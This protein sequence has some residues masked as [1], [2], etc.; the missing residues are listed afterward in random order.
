MKFIN[1]GLFYVNNSVTYPPF[2][3]GYYLE[4]F[5]FEFMKSHNKILD[6]EGRL[7]IPAL[8]TNF[9]I[10][11]W[12]KY[13]RSEMQ[14]S[15]N[16][17]IKNN[18][19]EKGYFTVVQHDDGP[20]LTL[21]NNTKVYGACSGNVP[22][23]L[24]YEDKNETLLKI[25]NLTKVDYNKKTTLCSFVGTV[26]HP[27]RKKC[28]DQLNN[29]S[30][31]SFIYKTSW[32]TDINK[33]SQ[34]LFIETT[35]NSRFAL[36]PRGY[37]RSSF[38]FF[39]ILQLGVIPV[40]VWNDIEWLPYKDKIDYKKFCISIH[41]DEIN[42]L[43]QILNNIKENTYNEMLANYEEIK[44]M[45]SL[46]NICEYITGNEDFSM[47]LCS[48]PIFDRSKLEPPVPDG[49]E[50]PSEDASPTVSGQRSEASQLLSSKVALLPENFGHTDRSRIS[51]CITTM[52]RFDTFLSKNL[53][54]Y[55][56]FLIDELIDEIIITDENGND[57]KKISEKYKHLLEQM[58]NFK[59]YKNEKIL[60]VFKNKLNACIYASCKYIALIDSDNFPDKKYFK[61]VKEY[62]N[63]NEKMFPEHIILAPSR[64]INHNDAPNLNYKEFEN[65]II[66]K[67]NIIEHIPKIK[68]QV[69]L[70]TGNYIISKSITDNI[71]YDNEIMDIISGCDVVY[72]NLLAFKQFSDLELHV[73]EGLEYSHTEHKDGEYNKRD[74]RCDYFRDRIIMPEYYRL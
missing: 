7:Y 17:Y 43:P 10:E 20:M 45:F 16:E 33:D 1:N 18:L 48:R 35:L 31:F 2:K 53:D 6:K 14:E 19:S 15:L 67:T 13:K 47:P 52:D 28:I 32:S 68:F 64:S 69:L 50:K 4:E 9:Q 27:I 3:N 63:K 37:G 5:F 49:S 21:P 61:T 25:K 57:Y 72:F 70:N 42:N 65:K 55:I 40:Y 23:P 38:R 44:D 36:A 62:I 51:L 26:T 60:G 22:L 71:N 34:T 59:I 58:P 12:F 29:I 24:I 30:G 11:D 56:E 41:E 8:W 73:I 54:N 66:N 46:N 74:Q 39:E